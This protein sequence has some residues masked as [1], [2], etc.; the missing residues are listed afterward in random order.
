MSQKALDANITS[1]WVHEPPLQVVVVSVSNESLIVREGKDVHH[2]TSTTFRYF[3]LTESSNSK[4]NKCVYDK[5]NTLRCTVA[6]SR[7]ARIAF[8][9]KRIVINCCTFP[10]REELLPEAGKW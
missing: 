3:V 2:F 6:A 8:T 1:I 4:Y 5:M 9:I 7:D 10:T